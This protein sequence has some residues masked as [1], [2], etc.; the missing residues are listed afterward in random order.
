MATER[1]KGITIQ[2]NGDTTKL[3]KAMREIKSSSK[4]IDKELKAV[5]QSLKF[6]PK[7]TV[8]LAQ[9]QTLLK[10]KV[11]DTKNQL[12]QFKDAQK[13]LKDQGVD[14]NT[15]EW[16]AL[17]RE[18]V[19]AES[20]VKY[21]EKSLKAMST[22][23]LEE[24]GSKFKNVGDKMTSLG[25]SMSTY[26]TAPIVGG[27]A[28][29]ANAASDYEENLNKVEVAFGKNAEAVKKWSETATTEFGLSKNAALEMTSQFGDMGTSMGLS[30]ED[31]AKMSTT[32]AGLAGDL[33][34]FKNIGI[35]QAMTALNGVFTGETESLKTLGVVMTQDNLKQFAADCG[36]VFDELSQAEM[37]TLR[38]NY[39][40]E[41]TKNAQ[42]D[43]ANTADGTAN[44]IRTF[45]ES[46][47]NL[48]VVIGEEIL[49]IITPMIQKAGEMV[50]G[51][52]EMSPSTKKLV[53]VLGL[54][55][56][57]AGPVLIFIGSIASAIGVL[58]PLIGGLELASLGVVA[59]FLAIAAAIAAVIAIGVLLYKH[60]DTVKEKA[61]DLGSAIAYPFKKA[62]EFIKRVVDKI[63]A[64]FPFK[65][66][67]P[68]FGISPKG[69][70]PSDL[71]KGSIPKLGINW[72]KTGGIFNSPSVIGVGEGS[73]SEAVVPLDKFWAQMDNM[74][75]SIVAAIQI[76]MSGMSTAGAIDLTV[77]L[78]GAKV[79]EEIVKLYDRTK[80]AVK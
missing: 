1:V 68:H 25:K 37:V 71:L 18:I 34:S 53:I 77:N 8:L 50:Q 33:A 45:K 62:W 42:G 44:S 4:D 69:W 56:A 74:T 14:S 64:L 76:G 46:L 11:E 32:L 67:M 49:P 59:P 36:L 48:A 19:Q 78:G 22:A 26:V 55:A 61:A 10:E 52:S 28:Y 63:K 58:I 7:N 12:N 24:L 57:A 40:L 16:R 3:N 15:A 13:Q 30:T 29:A 27:F 2:F 43:Y 75:Q 47:N 60:W 9:K 6:D 35:D 5:N 21:F 41:K 51:F 65:V 80:K 70:S 20:K 54:L 39:V 23:K 38:Y 79:G 73:S 72:Y 66:K 17:E 31:A